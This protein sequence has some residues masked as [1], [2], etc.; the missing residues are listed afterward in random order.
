M[1]TLPVLPAI[2]LIPFI[3]L[4]VFL[5]ALSGCADDGDEQ[6]RQAASE[7]R[8]RAQSYLNQGQLRAALIEAQ[9]ADQALPGQAETLALS[10]RIF[11][12]LGTLDKAQ[13]VLEKLAAADKLDAQSTLDFGRVLVRRGRFDRALILLQDSEDPDAMGIRAQALVGNGQHGQAITLAQQALKKDAA[14]TEALIALANAQFVA[15]ERDAVQATL[16]QLTA[17]D[18]WRT[19]LW[20]ARLEQAMEKHEAAVD[21]LGN[22]LTFLNQQDI[23]TAWRFEAL[24]RMMQSLITLGRADEALTYSNA[25]AD[26]SAGQLASR[27]D[28][29]VSKIREGNLDEASALFRDILAQSPGH[30]GSA[31]ALGLIAFQQKDFQDARQYLADAVESGNDSATAIKYLVTTLLQSGDNA[32]A[33]S[34]LDKALDEYPGDPDLLALQGLALQRS[35]ELA[36]ARTIFSATLEKQP[37]NVGAHI[38]LG[39]IALEEGNAEQAERYF[40][41]ALAIQPQAPAALRGLVQV[42]DARGLR[43]A[44]M[45]ELRQQAR[46]SNNASL[47]LLAATTALQFED[48]DGARNDARKALD[49]EPG[50]ARA[51]ALLGALDYLDARR[52]F[53]RQA[54]ADAFSLASRGLEF[55]PDNLGLMLLKASAATA[56]GNAKAA[57]AVADSLKARSPDSHHGHELEGDIHTQLGN[58]AEAR[59]AYARAWQHQR[60]PVLAGKYVNALNATGEDGLS[61]LTQWTEAEPDDP[62][63]WLTLAGAQEQAGNTPAAQA[64]YE[65]VA[66]LLPDSAPVL[67]NL[68]W[69]YHQGGDDRAEATAAQAYALAPDNAAIAD[70]YGWILL[71][72]GDRERALKLLEQAAAGAPENTDIQAHLEAARAGG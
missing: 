56:E 60:N 66:A 58:S 45:A 52:A 6:A 43:S 38:S 3:L 61:V 42:A 49:A 8:F 10:A 11:M 28:A 64:A 35:G 41:Q 59:D 5:A 27:Y 62:R 21:S 50:N 25:L 65:Q 15:G 54:F 9:N 72:N 67:N 19:W 31:M 37:G 53:S 2:R 36:Q 26:S 29:A 63:A 69:L 30:S 55:M 70:T 16:E 40:R 71:Q 12:A 68:A 7:Y 39:Q 48:S 1:P 34:Y 46:S 23:M 33:L 32:E 51:R 24:R 18:N 13:P 20:R 44:G 14:A 22:A 4:A 57:F 17:E 47:W